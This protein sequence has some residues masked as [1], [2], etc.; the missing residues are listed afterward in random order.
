[1]KLQLFPEARVPGQL[2]RK[3]FAGG[4]T[5]QEFAAF[6]DIGMLSRAAASHHIL[7]DFI[8][9]ID[10]KRVWKKSGVLV[11]TFVELLRVIEIPLPYRD[12]MLS[13]RLGLRDAVKRQS[14]IHALLFIVSGPNCCRI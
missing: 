14:I 1:V 9:S 5:A 7:L 3:P 6:A 8:A 4:D 13:Q 2:P 12:K 11:I 10:A